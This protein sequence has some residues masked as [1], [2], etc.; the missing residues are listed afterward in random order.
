[1][2]AIMRTGKTFILLTLA[3]AGAHADASEEGG[4]ERPLYHGMTEDRE[5]SAAP[6]PGFTLSSSYVDA[7]P[8]VE[9]RPDMRGLWVAGLKLEEQSRFVEAARAYEKI[10]LQMPDSSF[11][12]WRISRANWRVGDSLAEGATEAKIEYFER[13]ENWARR[14]MELDPGCA[15]CMLWRYASLGRLITNRGLASGVRHARLMSHLLDD[16]IELQPSHR[17]AE[18]N[19]TLGN[20]YYA[21]AI[22]NRMVP[23]WFWLKWV[24]GVRGD[25]ELALDDIDNAIAISGGRIDYHV[26]KGAVLMC[27]GAARD[28]PERIEQGREVLRA[29]F[30]MQQRL[31]SD[32]VDLAYAKVLIKEPDK[33]CGYSRDGFVDVE[34]AGRSL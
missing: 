1:M 28:L 27:L 11:A 34:A 33:A 7:L 24:V 3:V 9:E 18:W 31:G 29:T 19:T 2:R 6:P 13:A 22:F 14:G 10:A 21:R 15:E 17:E 8:G 12:Y 26:E 16:A 20:L 32:A 30:G 25:K 4:A 23:D 5:V